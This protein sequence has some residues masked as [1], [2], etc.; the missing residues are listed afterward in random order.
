MAAAEMYYRD[1][2]GENVDSGFFLGSLIMNPLSDF[3]S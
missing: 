1:N 3:Q 2:V